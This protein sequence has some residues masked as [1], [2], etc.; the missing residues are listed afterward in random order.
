MIS[1]L[2]HDLAVP[3]LGSSPTQHGAGYVT[4]TVGIHLQ[5]PHSGRAQRNLWSILPVQPCEPLAVPSLGSSPT[6][7]RPYLYHLNRPL[8]TSTRHV[9]NPFSPSWKKLVVAFL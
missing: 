5:Y 1:C 8:T 9:T 3:S 7:L 2:P 4:K 6:Q